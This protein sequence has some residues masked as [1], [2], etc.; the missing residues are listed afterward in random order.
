MCYIHIYYVTVCGEIGNNATFSIRS[1][2]KIYHL[3]SFCLIFKKT[4]FILRSLVS[5]ADMAKL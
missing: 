4:P 2:N 3:G 1:C 5:A